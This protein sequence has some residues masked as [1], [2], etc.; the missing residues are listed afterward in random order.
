MKNKKT[1]I[2]MS[3][4]PPPYMG[5]TIA[6]EII[7]NSRLKDEFDLIHLDTSD[8]RGLHTLGA[9]DFQN[10]HLAFKHY[11]RLGWLI[12]TRW[13]DVVYAPISQT[14]RGYLRDAGFI[15]IAKLLRI[16]VICHLRGGNFRNWYLSSKRLNSSKAIKF[17]API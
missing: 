13:P 7:L 2:F 3:P 8:H 5:P 14:T 12:L 6:T 15:L 1:I 16:K 4:T 9:I 11:L 10:V 17:T